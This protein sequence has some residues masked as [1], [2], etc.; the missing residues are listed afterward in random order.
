MDSMTWGQSKGKYAG[1]RWLGG[2]I[3]FFFGFGRQLL[4][5]GG[6]IGLGGVSSREGGEEAEDAAGAGDE[7]W[8]GG[9]DSCE[10]A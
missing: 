2:V 10:D 9:G 8:E 5:R 7:A 6:G 1:V 4:G 3:P